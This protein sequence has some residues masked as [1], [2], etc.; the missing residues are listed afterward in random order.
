MLFN[1]LLIS[2][3]P[4]ERKKSV[5]SY[6]YRVRNECEKHNI[7]IHS[8]FAG[9]SIYA[10]N[11]LYH[12]LAEGRMDGVDWFEHAFKMTN[13]LGV[14]ATGRPLGGLDIS[15]FLNDMRRNT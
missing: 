3:T 2:L 9:L 14:K 10:H 6:C 1:F 5:E 11:L 15:S 7:T 8:T 12:P 4:G 13:L